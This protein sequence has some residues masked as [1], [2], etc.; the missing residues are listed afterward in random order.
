MLTGPFGKT[1]NPLVHHNYRD[2]AHFVSKQEQYVRY[3]AQILYG[4]GVQPKTRN[5]YSAAVT[6]LSLALC[7]AKGLP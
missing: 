7:H 5:F 6:T 1:I 4:Q 3:D 2:L